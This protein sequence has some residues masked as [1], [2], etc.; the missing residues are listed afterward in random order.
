MY[1]SK[2][3]ILKHGEYI[4]AGT[5]VQSDREGKELVG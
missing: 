2:I 3:W 4:A 5:Q 1:S